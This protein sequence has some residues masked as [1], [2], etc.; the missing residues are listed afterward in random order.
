MYYYAVNKLQINSITHK[1]L[2][3][4][5]TQNEGDAA[6]SVIEK[7]VTRA[8]KSGAIYVPDQ[9]ISLI[10]N[11]K[12]TGKPFIV[13]ELNYTD[14]MDLKKLADDLNINTTRNVSGEAIKTTDIKVI[15]FMKD[16]DI[17][18]YKT[19][20]KTDNLNEA[21]INGKTR[22]FRLN[23]TQTR[24]IEEISLNPAY[25]SNIPISDRKKQDLLELVQKNIVPRYYEH[26]YNQL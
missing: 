16:C 18:K 14:F 3:K 22:T 1:F 10:R 6:H 17:Y 25:T 8:K 19:T 21:N 7:S 20:Y 13:K 2:I 11:A 12:K 4:G 26:F 5:H 9:Y 24:N 15:R 23:T